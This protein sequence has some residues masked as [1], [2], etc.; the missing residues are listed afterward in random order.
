MTAAGFGEERLQMRLAVQL[1]TYVSLRRQTF[2]PS[3][4]RQGPGVAIGLRDCYVHL[5]A[6][7]HDYSRRCQEESQRMDGVE[8]E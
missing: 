8:S 3:G 6:F 5:L 1:T 2:R 4:S 7:G